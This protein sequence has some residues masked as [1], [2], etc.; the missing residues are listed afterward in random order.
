MLLKPKVLVSCSSAASAL[1]F[2]A[3]G[4]SRQ[5][6]IWVGGLEV[7]EVEELVKL[8]GHSAD[9]DSIKNIVAKCAFPAHKPN[10]TL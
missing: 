10:S 4:S 7:E 2:D 1:S 8:H 3:G 9:C 5:K 6:N